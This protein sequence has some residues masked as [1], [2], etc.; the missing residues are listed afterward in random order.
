MTPVQDSG[1][2]SLVEEPSS[3]GKWD[4]SAV[5]SE[6]AGGRRRGLRS[7]VAVNDWLIGF[8][9]LAIDVISW[10][11]IYGVTTYL[12]SDNF[13]VGPFE[14]L[15]VDVVQLVVICQA[16]FMIGGYDRNNDTRTLTYTAE[17]ILAIAGAAA[18][19]SLL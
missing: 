13:L 5:A 14:F 1:M 9:C 17:H 19:S 15:L 3:P 4:E 10:V 6:G 8:L 11:V 7:A 16:L 18:I 12:R 2:P